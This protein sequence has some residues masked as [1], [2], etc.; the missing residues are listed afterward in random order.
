MTAIL[1][2]I[3]AI[4]CCTWPG[5][6]NRPVWPSRSTSSTGSTLGA[7]TAL[8]MPQYSKIFIGEP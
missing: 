6:I 3:W 5:S 2:T 8:P 1:L 7:I 4:I